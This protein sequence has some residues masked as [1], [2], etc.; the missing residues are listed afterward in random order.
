MAARALADVPGLAERDALESAQAKLAIA[1]GAVAG[2]AASEPLMQVALEPEAE[3]LATVRRALDEGRQV[4][5]RYLVASRDEVT[6]R[7]VDPMRLVSVDGR[8]YLE[9]WCHVAE[10]T[11]LF[12]LDRMVDARL[13]AAAEPLPSE[14]VPRDLAEGLF[15]P[16]DEDLTVVLELEP[17][18][19]WVAD[20]YP[21]EQ[22]TELGPA[23]GDDAAGDGPGPLRVEL[24][25]PDPGWVVRLALR[26]GGRGRVVSPPD[27]VAAVREQAAAALAA[28]GD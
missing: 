20:Y 10:A 4:E 27:V 13:G 2:A 7:T 15:R 17:A 24:R 11:R 3:A 5:L 8:W 21:V 6:E 14:A 12:R 25:T 16:R 18:A 28:L 9:G 26:L 1:S 19:R 23:A 22:S